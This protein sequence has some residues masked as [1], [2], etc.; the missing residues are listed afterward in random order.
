MKDGEDV[1]VI[2]GKGGDR[3][4]VFNKVL[5]RVSD[6]FVLE[7]HVDV[8]EANAACLKNGDKVFVL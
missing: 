6:K 2:C 4:L 5:V 3:E 1:S 7:M 8:E